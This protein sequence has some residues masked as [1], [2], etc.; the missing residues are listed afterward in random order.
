[1]SRKHNDTE[2]GSGMEYA[3]AKDTKTL[4]EFWT[5]D[6]RL[7]QKSCDSLAYATCQK[8]DAHASPAPAHAISAQLMKQ[9]EELMRLRAEAGSN[10]RD[11]GSARAALAKLQSAARTKDDKLRQLRDAFRTLEG[12]LVDA[13]KRIADR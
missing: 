5:C 9:N 6:F 4:D 1:M 8:V 3:C 11:E 2:L 10:A 13:H 12:K 7:R